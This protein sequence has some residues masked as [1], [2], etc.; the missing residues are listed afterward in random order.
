[1]YMVELPQLVVGQSLAGSTV[2]ASLY[3][4]IIC[5][6][7]IMSMI[8]IGTLLAY[9]NHWEHLQVLSTQ[10]SDQN[11]DRNVPTYGYRLQ[12]G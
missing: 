4:R 7:D 10:Q 8:D 1:M 11:S 3:N 5:I 2:T 6:D 12:I 9:G